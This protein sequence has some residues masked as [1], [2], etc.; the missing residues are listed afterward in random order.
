MSLRSPHNEKLVRTLTILFAA[1][2][3][4][5]LVEDEYV[6]CN[7]VGGVITNN[8]PA[9]ATVLGLSFTF[10]KTDATANAVVLDGNGAETINGALTFS[11]LAQND[12]VTIL[13]L[14]AGWQILNSKATTS[15]GGVI[16][17]GTYAAA[18]GSPANGDLHLCT[19]SPIER[20]R[21]G[22]VWVDYLPA[23]TG[24]PAVTIPVAATFTPFS[25]GVRTDVGGLLLVGGVSGSFQLRG[26]FNASPVAAPWRITA[27]FEGPW[28]DV[29]GGLNAV[30]FFISD[31]TKY[32][33]WYMLTSSGGQ[34]ACRMD[35]WNTLTDFAATAKSLGIGRL[36]QQNQIYGIRG[37]DDGVNR[38]FQYFDLDGNWIN[39]DTTTNGHNEQI[40]S[41][42]VTQW[43][44]ILLCD[45]ATYQ[46]VGRFY[47][48]D[49]LAGATG[50]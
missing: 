48:A 29:G 49:M 39:V 13:A 6:E 19:D 34:L 22:G 43:G 9:L 25:A 40:A 10:A 5:V 46:D 8:L 33:V 2:P 44:V 27:Y 36:H 21:S 1:S 42:A 30:G 12:V 20:Y 45:S 4:T 28:H 17:F 3:Y 50:P 7:A 11:L 47:R 41:A 14:A 18:P 24:R 38:L 16:T 15:S 37:A 31:G 32:I 35:Y 26:G 23:L